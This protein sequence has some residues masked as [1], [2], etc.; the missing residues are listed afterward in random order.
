MDNIL[1]IS[2]KFQIS[3]MLQNKWKL[4]SIILSVIARMKCPSTIANF[5]PQIRGNFCRSGN[6]EHHHSES[7]FSYAQAPVS[8]F[9]YKSHY[10]KCK[11]TLTRLIPEHRKRVIYII[12]LLVVLATFVKIRYPKY[13]LMIGDLGEVQYW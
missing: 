13:E 12:G 1:A 2:S 10:E 3:A 5:P 6:T 9:L 7:T 8:T 4:T 11:G